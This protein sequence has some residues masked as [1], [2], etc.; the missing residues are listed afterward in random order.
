MSATTA[1]LEPTVFINQPLLDFSQ[2]EE[3]ER[4]AEAL[5]AT[6]RE[7]G[8]IY[9]AAVRQEQLRPAQLPTS[10]EPGWTKSINPSHPSEIVGWV[11]RSGTAEAEKAILAAKAAYEEWSRVPVEQRARSL[12]KTAD[13]MQARRYQYAAWA[14]HEAGKPWREADADVCEAIDFLRYY[15]LEMRKL[16]IPTVLQPLPGESNEYLYV[17]LGPGIIIAPWN[18]PLAILTGMTAAAIVAGNTVVMKPAEQT[19]VCAWEVFKAFQ[20]GG[21]LPPGVLSYLPGHGDVGEYL[22]KRPE[23]CFIAFTGSVDVGLKINEAAGQINP[24]RDHV[25]RVI[26][27]MGGKNAIIVDTSA[28]LDAAVGGVVRSAFYYAGQKCSAA[29]RVLVLDSVYDSFVSRLQDAA[30]SLQVGPAEDPATQVGP[31]IDSEAVQRVC[32]HGGKK[33][34]SGE[35]SFSQLVNPL[36]VEIAN[37]TCDLAQKEIFGPIA[38]VLRVRN[39]AEAIRTANATR[40]ALTAGLYSRT[41]E[42]IDLVR[43]ELQ[44]GNVYINRPITGSIVG[45]QPFGG[46]KLSGIGS[47]AGGPDYLR[48]FLMPKTITENTMRHGFAPEIG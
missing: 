12:E 18:F 25:T 16:D 43:R 29:S 24:E 21:E 34:S 22:V 48:Q 6:R 33:P 2:E 4:F 20:E 47:K 28:D 11:T 3:R 8:R 31:L 14:V 45:R 46:F 9:P 5:A 41:P 37:D 1:G 15:A 26:A 7:F 42:H 32:Q 23:T 19:P 10:G 30:S 40:Y 44:A 17:P 39:I 38:A 13:Y 35:N 27:E 36:V